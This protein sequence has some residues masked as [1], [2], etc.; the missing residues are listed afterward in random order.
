MIL[1]SDFDSSERISEDIAISNSS[2]VILR[3]IVNGNISVAQNSSLQ[4]HGI[5]NGSITIDADC[6]F[7]LHGTINGNIT[8]FGTTHIY[9]TAKNCLLSGSNIHIH[10]NALVNGEEIYFDKFE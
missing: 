9:G 5:V 2:N 10:K 1:T 4:L 6:N 8:N 3:G 7:N